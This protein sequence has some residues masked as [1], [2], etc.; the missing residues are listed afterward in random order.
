MGLLDATAEW[1]KARSAPIKRWYRD[2]QGRYGF[3][4]AVEGEMFYVGAVSQTHRDGKISVMD[5]L[6][7][8]ARDHDAMLLI[9]VSDDFRVFHPDM[10]RVPSDGHGTIRK[11]RARR[12]ETWYRADVDHSVSFEDYMDGV[13]E[14]RQRHGDLSDFT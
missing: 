14:P 5:K 10:F 2:D 12:G 3:R 1:F 8:R 4:V 11:E 7:E 13:A 9:R 6:V